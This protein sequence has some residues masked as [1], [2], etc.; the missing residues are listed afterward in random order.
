MWFSIECTACQ[1]QRRGRRHV[2]YRQACPRRAVFR[3]TASSAADLHPRQHPECTA[4]LLTRKAINHH[5][6]TPGCRKTVRRIYGLRVANI[7]SKTARNAIR[8]NLAITTRGSVCLQC[9]QKCDNVLFVSY[10]NSM[11]TA[12][13]QTHRSATWFLA[14]VNQIR[15]F[16]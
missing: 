13:Q 11:Q 14:R 12:T 10:V 5:H 2:E 6:N 8:T 1:P 16:V 3:S 7:D 4:L 9:T 15:R